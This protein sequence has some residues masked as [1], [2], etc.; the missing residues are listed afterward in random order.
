M[1]YATCSLHTLA[2]LHLYAAYTHAPYTHLLDYIATKERCVY[3]RYMCLH[4]K[5]PANRAHG[6]HLECAHMFLQKSFIS[7]Q[8]SPLCLQ[9]RPRCLHKRPR[10]LAKRP[11][12][13]HTPIK[14]YIC[15]S[16]SRHVC[17]YRHMCAPILNKG[18]TEI[19]N[20]LPYACAPVCC[21]VLQCVAEC[22]V[23]SNRTHEASIAQERSL[24]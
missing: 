7:L 21:S 19:D 22:C 6:W 12:C 20:L 4:T 9:K 17:Y 10:C 5:S 8:K 2:R 18:G 3:K 16:T 13:G 15:V 14:A 24:E 1:Q 11:L 23:V